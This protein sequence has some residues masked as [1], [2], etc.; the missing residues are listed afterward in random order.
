VKD[1]KKPLAGMAL[2]DEIVAQA[3]SKKAEKIVLLDMGPTSSVTDW[4][5][6]CQGD[7]P[8]HARAVAGAVVTG[9]KHR[10]TYPWVTEGEMEARWV[11]IDYV[12]VVVQVMTPQAREYYALE[13]LWADAPRTEITSE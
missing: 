1:S 11:L 12:D 7:N 9:L 6:I 3:E 4:F 2:V 10:Q 8:L 13:K 5:V